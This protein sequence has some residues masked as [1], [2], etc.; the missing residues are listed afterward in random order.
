MEDEHNHSA[1]HLKLMQNNMECKLQLKNKL[2][3]SKEYP[4]HSW[5]DGLWWSM[6]NR[7]AVIRQ[8]ACCL[9]HSPAP[10]TLYTLSLRVSITSANHTAHS[11]W[12]SFPESSLC[13]SLCSCW[14]FHHWPS[15]VHSVPVPKCEAQSPVMVAPESRSQW[16]LERH[17][18]TIWLLAH[19]KVILTLLLPMRHPYFSSLRCLEPSLK[20][21][22]TVLF[23]IFQ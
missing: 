23:S 19:H 21:Y 20:R 7:A 17:A 18:N 12:Q 2:L 5:E 22:C 3:K 11:L 14:L 9:F 13:F 8:A 1:M 10:P 6:W 15:S 16:V 4:L